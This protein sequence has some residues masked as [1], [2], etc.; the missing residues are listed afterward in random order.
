VN[1]AA[2]VVTLM[3]WALAAAHGIALLAVVLR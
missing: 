3:L 1:R 2:I